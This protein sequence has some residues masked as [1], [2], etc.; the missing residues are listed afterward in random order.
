M[1]QKFVSFITACPHLGD[2]YC[3]SGTQFSPFLLLSPRLQALATG[4][5]E[6]LFIEAMSEECKDLEMDQLV[7]TLSR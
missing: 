6:H 2:L 1:K 4:K 7:T 3:F 5:M